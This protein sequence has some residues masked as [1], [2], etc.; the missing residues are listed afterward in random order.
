MGNTIYARDGDKFMDTYLPTCG[1]WF[2]KSVR[3]F[4]LRMGVIN[5]QCF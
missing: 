1:T 5:N 2:G 3:E 4:K